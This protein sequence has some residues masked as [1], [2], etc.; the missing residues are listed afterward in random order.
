MI[1]LKGN[2]VP[3]AELNIYFF[4]CSWIVVEEFMG[5]QTWNLCTVGGRHIGNLLRALRQSSLWAQPQIYVSEG[6]HAG[7]NTYL[8]PLQRSHNLPK[9]YLFTDN[10][11]EISRLTTAGLGK[12]KNTP[13]HLGARYLHTWRWIHFSEY[14][15]FF[16]ISI[17]GQ[18][19]VMT[20]IQIQSSWNACEKV[21][22]QTRNEIFLKVVMLS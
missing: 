13:S 12:A 11:N 2:K 9:T 18:W 22:F 4:L 1:D 3:S 20:S 5:L 15:L 17:S 16:Y 6:I 10:L 19:I 21:A 14:Q 7:F 8:V